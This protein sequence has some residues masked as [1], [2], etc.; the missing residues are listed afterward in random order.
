MK[1]RVHHQMLTECHKT[2][3]T[4]LKIYAGRMSISSLMLSD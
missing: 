4:W 2:C 3:I 1:H